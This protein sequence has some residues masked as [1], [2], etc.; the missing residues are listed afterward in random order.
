MNNFSSSFKNWLVC[1]LIPWIDI[2]LLT[3]L[4]AYIQDGSLSLCNKF[5]FGVLRYVLCSCSNNYSKLGCFL[6]KLLQRCVDMGF[7]KSSKT[8]A[9]TLN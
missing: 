4:T 9:F 3:Q 8:I 6:R 5:L 1:H 2:G 7:Q